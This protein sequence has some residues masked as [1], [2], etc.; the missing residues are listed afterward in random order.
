MEGLE[1]VNVF[2]IKMGEFSNIGQ[3]R[4]ITK[5]KQNR[6][7]VYSLGNFQ[8]HVQCDPSN[9]NACVSS[10]ITSPLLE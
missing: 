10:G 9:R 4:H 6:T 5:R 2:R 7:N 1:T 8:S 3:S